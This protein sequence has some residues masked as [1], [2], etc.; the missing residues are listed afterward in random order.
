MKVG[1]IGLGRMGR[2]MALNLIKA[3][4]EVTVFDLSSEAV[5][6]LTS[7]GAKA[8]ASIADLT[9]TTDVVFT[10]L[11][12]PTEVEAVVFGKNGI[13]DNI[14]PGKVL[15]D[16]STSS[17]DMALRISKAFAEKGA[18]MLDAP[19]SGG[20]AGAQSGDMAFWV[21]GDQETYERF[22][23]VL[24]A[25]GDKPRRVG[26]IG[27]GTVVKLVNNVTGP[28]FLLA[29]SEA[30]SVGVKAGVDP[31]ELWD[32]L[33]LG[34]LGKGS[35]LNMLTKQFLPGQFDPPAFALKL[36]YKDVNLATELAK[37]LGVP[38]RLASLT[39][40]EMAEALSKGQGDL[41]G[42]IYL[43]LQ[44]ERAGVKIAV[45]P[46]KLAE[47]AANPVGKTD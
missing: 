42:R 25:M 41:D 18:T 33:R 11:P 24:K 21:G 34:V 8:A 1:Y 47:R 17:R 28:M 7:S 40:A 30:F 46:E 31:L 36:M 37:E 10:S 12:G 2:G 16:L 15:F 14:G 4:Y 6:A 27:M 3:G 9:E 5:A 19:V 44:L 35:A 20:P 23:P 45:D 29:M 43:Q 39:H 22:L 32:A 38:M 13:L 26:E